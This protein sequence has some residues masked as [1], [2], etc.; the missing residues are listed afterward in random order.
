MREANVFSEIHP[1]TITTDKVKELKPSGIILSGGPMSVY[2]E[3]APKIDPEILKLNIPV[4][5]ICYGLQFI[6]LT[7][8]GKVEPAADR[9]Y[10]KA[11][12]RI[13]KESTLL[14]GVKEES[15]VW[16]SHGDYLNSPPDNF[17]IIGTSD[18]SPVCAVADEDRN[19][20]GLQFHPEVM[21][22][23]KGKNNY[24]QFFI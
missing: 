6:A 3:G 20:Y 15:I 22:T 5:G 17:E 4:L 19:I 16:M 24:P 9:E 21:H 7:L 8:G 18:H 11:I 1:H 23:E 10:G 12:F 13:K 2:D 14:A